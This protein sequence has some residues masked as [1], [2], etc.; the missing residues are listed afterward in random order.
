MK[1]EICKKRNFDGVVPTEGEYPEP[2]YICKECA[3]FYPNFDKDGFPIF[4]FKSETGFWYFLYIHKQYLIPYIYPAY[5]QDY[6]HLDRD[7]AFVEKKERKE[8]KIC[9]RVVPYK[10]EQPGEEEVIFFSFGNLSEES[11]QNL[12]VNFKL[13]TKAKLF[14]VKKKETTSK[15]IINI[16]LAEEE[17]YV[18]GNL[19]LFP[20]EEEL[21]K[22]ESFY[23]ATNVEF[24]CRRVV[25]YIET[26]QP[27]AAYIYVIKECNSNLKE[28]KEV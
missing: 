8:E 11:L 27:V 10:Y 13:I 6:R 1:C 9:K 14:G 18:E 12:N 2:L 7:K 22:I 24:E 15:G 3:S 21:V 5:R 17:D 25:V 28:L 4:H 26:G 19:F 20:T 23:Q 16:E